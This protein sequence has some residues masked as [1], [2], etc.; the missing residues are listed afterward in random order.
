MIADDSSY[1][2]IERRSTL[3]KTQQ[4]TFYEGELA[5]KTGKISKTKIFATILKDDP[6]LYVIDMKLVPRTPEGLIQDRINPYH[7]PAS[8]DG[9][10]L[11]PSV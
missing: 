8:A 10:D 1:T 4:L 9:I 7:A 6:S 3:T 2:P 11:A 5:W